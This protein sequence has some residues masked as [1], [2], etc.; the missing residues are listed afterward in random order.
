M[1]RALS[2]LRSGAALLLLC[3]GAAFL[4]HLCLYPFVGAGSPIS[5]AV[6]HGAVMVVVLWWVQRSLA[7]EVVIRR[8]DDGAVVR[9]TYNAV[10]LR[11][12]PADIHTAAHQVN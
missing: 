7:L 12:L 10:T 2:I 4:V 6:A 5:D 9:K 8:T 3:A 11:N 1:K